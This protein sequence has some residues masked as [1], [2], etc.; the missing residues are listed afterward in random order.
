MNVQGKPCLGCSYGLASKA[1]VTARQNNPSQ[2]A[3]AAS[4]SLVGA[5]CQPGLTPRV[6]LLPRPPVAAAP[7]SGPVP[8]TASSASWA[9]SYS[10]CQQ[11]PATSW[12]RKQPAQPREQEWGRRAGRR[13]ARA[14][15]EAGRH[16]PT[17]KQAGN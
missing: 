8:C 5:P 9:Y 6:L 1:P 14:R 11:V 12:V 3:H 7:A 16:P 4:A 10:S 17:H 15:W 13:E 2:Q